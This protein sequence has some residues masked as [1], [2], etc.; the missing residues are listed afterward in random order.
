MDDKFEKEFFGETPSNLFYSESEET[1]QYRHQYY[2][3]KNKFFLL[4]LIPTAMMVASIILILCYAIE[5]IAK[6]NS[7]STLIILG[8]VLLVVGYVAKI[9]L[10][11]IR[12]NLLKPIKTDIKRSILNDQLELTGANINKNKTTKDNKTMN[13]SQTDNTLKIKLE[14]QE[15][16]I[17][18]L[19]EEL[20][21]QVNTK[22][23]S[24]TSELQIKLLEQEKEILKLKQQLNNQ[25]EIKNIDEKVKTNKTEEAYKSKD[26][27]K[28]TSNLSKSKKINYIKIILYTLVGLCAVGFVVS[29]MLIS[30]SITNGKVNL[31]PIIITVTLPIIAII[32]TTVA[33]GLE[34]E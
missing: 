28:L 30:K 24:L 19:K 17:K 15:E 29:L 27:K 22:T 10:Y 33:M 9:V 32:I 13:I 5:L 26:V 2:N 23:N 11:E 6:A 34:K 3:M 20:S 21:E 31:L 4:G 8:V 25:R 14:K 16:V 18:N 1:R 7:N 12:N